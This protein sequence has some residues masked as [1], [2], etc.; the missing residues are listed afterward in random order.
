MKKTPG[1]SRRRAGE[2]APNTNGG[3]AVSEK[4]VS[5]RLV[6]NY[7]EYLPIHIDFLLYNIVC[8][9]LSNS[10]Q[11]LEG[12]N[13]RIYAVRT[14]IFSIFFGFGLG[15]PSIYL[16]SSRK[17]SCLQFTQTKVIRGFIV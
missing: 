10:N 9:C 6:R 3:C 5:R 8:G 11:V 16:T 4:A 17:T 15:V 7:S 2:L 12:K 13:V 1:V 14:A